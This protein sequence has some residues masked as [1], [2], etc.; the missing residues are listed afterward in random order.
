MYAV[1]I[2]KFPLQR[3]W[4]LFRRTLEPFIC[5]RVWHKTIVCWTGIGSETL[6]YVMQEIHRFHKK[7]K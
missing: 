5:K 3:L 7:G 4:A 1:R 2:T 6:Q